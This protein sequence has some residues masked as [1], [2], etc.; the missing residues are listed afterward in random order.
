MVTILHDN[1]IYTLSVVAIPNL[2]RASR[3]KWKNA[4]MLDLE[5]ENVNIWGIMLFLYNQIHSAKRIQ[6]K[7]FIL[8]MQW[9]KRDLHCKSRISFDDCRRIHTR[10]EMVVEVYMGTKFDRKGE[11]LIAKKIDGFFYL[12]K[13]DRKSVGYFF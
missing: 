8:D 1:V 2:D 7:L 11:N 13:N 5:G 3:T 4:C 10:K 12:W 6:S 9:K